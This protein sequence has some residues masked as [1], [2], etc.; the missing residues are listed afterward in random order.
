MRQYGYAFQIGRPAG[1]TAEGAG[2]SLVVLPDMDSFQLSDGLTIE[3]LVR[4]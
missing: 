4:E 2:L 3:T 1:S